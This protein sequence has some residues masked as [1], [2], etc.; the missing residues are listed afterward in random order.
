V[1]AKLQLLRSKG[2]GGYDV[3]AGFR[4]FPV[5]L[6]DGFGAGQV[7]ELRGR[8]N[9]KPALLEHRAHRAVKYYKIFF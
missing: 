6:S 8:A 3:R 1:P 9:R 4:V 7:Q 5:Y 2:V